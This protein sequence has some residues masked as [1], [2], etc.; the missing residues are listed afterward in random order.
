MPQNQRLEVVMG[1]EPITWLPKVKSDASKSE[2]EAARALAGLKLKKPGK[3]TRVRIVNALEDD[4]DEVGFL[5]DNL[6][7][8]SPLH[9]LLEDKAH[10]VSAEKDSQSKNVEETSDAIGIVLP[11]IPDVKEITERAVAAHS[12]R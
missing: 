2:L 11:I 7:L 9:G 1:S 8:V 4:D 6:S 12:E 3:K 10:D 5:D